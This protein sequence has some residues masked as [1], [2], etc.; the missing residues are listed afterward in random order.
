MTVVTVIHVCRDETIRSS[1][2]TIGIDTKGDDMVIFDSIR[3]DTDNNCKN[4][5]I[6]NIHILLF[7][8][9]TEVCFDQSVLQT[10]WQGSQ[11]N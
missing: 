3:Y 11:R 4:T 9:T 6:H 7:M 1:H 8:N 2:D 5:N 10:Q